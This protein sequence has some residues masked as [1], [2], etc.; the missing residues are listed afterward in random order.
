[1]RGAGKCFLTLA[2]GRDYKD[3]N[4]AGTM[5]RTYKR[6][7]LRR[8][9]QH[10]KDWVNVNNGADRG[11]LVG[12]TL[13]SET[14]IGAIGDILPEGQSFPRIGDYSRP[15]I[16]QF[17]EMM[18]DTWKG[19]IGAYADKYGACQ[20]PALDKNSTPPTWDQVRPPTDAGAIN[21]DQ[22]PEA[23]FNKA[24]WNNR[25]GIR[26]KMVPRMV[27]DTATWAI[28][29]GIPARRVWNHQSVDLELPFF[30]YEAS[31]LHTAAA[32]S[33]LPGFDLYEQQ[34]FCPTATEG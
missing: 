24:C 8:A 20:H 21:E 17:R 30:R 14:S 13:D 28:N 12:I 1:M 34:L 3:S 32:G 18:K 11:F 10:L 29:A 5:Y 6:N 23:P 7:N 25:Q 4:L 9:I 22:K 16:E 31:P 15:A 26:V 33:G 2:R 19:D 27:R